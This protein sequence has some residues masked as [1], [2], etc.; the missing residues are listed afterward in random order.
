MKKFLKE[1]VTGNPIKFL[2]FVIGILVIVALI[3]ANRGSFSREDVK[4]EILGPNEVSCGQEAEYVVKFKNNANFRIEDPRLNIE[5]PGQSIL[6][7]SDNNRVIKDAEEI[8]VLEP[9]QEKSFSIKARIL[10]SEGQFKDIN[11]LFSYQPKGLNAR[12]TAK[13]KFSVMIKSS[14]MSLNFDAQSKAEAGKDVQLYLNYFSKIDYPFSD[15]IIELIAPEGFTLTQ[16]DPPAID[17]NGNLIRFKIK[18]L[19]KGTGGRIKAIGT[20]TGQSG[21]TKSFEAKMGVNINN[22]FVLLKSADFQVIVEEPYVEINQTING[23]TRYNPSLNEELNYELTV[24]N[25]GGQEYKDTA[26]VVRLSGELFDLTSIQAN[27]ASFDSETGEIRWEAENNPGLKFFASNDSLKFNFKVRTKSGYESAVKN[28][29]LVNQ[30]S[31]GQAQQEFKLKVNSNFDLFQQAFI[32][33]EMFQ[34]EGPIPP[35]VGKESKVTL[36]WEIKNYFNDLKN[37]KVRVVLPDNVSLTG[38]VFPPEESDRFTF[39]TKSREVVWNIGDISSQVGISPK[40]PKKTI[41]F[42][43]AIVPKEEQKGTG[44]I[45]TESPRITG[46]DQWTGE[47]IEKSFEPLD[48]RA[49]NEEQGIVK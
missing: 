39:D 15:V 46:E 49:I 4:L 18:S 6:V 38:Q 30:V 36:I 22:E 48:T 28:P 7:G 26:L 31:I 43:L 25:V 12:W 17:Q 37:V 16:S 34:S 10:G 45:L 24:R 42:Q 32:L 23:Q 3:V 14:N 2:L 35:Q 9:G 8:G 11:V 33:D 21:Q 47:T 41:G 20:L 29:Y 27:N 19:T 13:T 5:F 1:N 44:A 40:G